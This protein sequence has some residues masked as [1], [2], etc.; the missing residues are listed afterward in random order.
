MPMNVPPD[1]DTIELPPALRPLAKLSMKPPLLMLPVKVPPDTD[2]VELSWALRPLAVLLAVHSKPPPLLMKPVRL[3]ADMDTTEVSAA[4][5]PLAE[6]TLQPPVLML[7]VRVAALSMTR[8][9]SKTL[10]A[11][12]LAVRNPPSDEKAVT[13]PPA[14]K[15]TTVLFKICTWSLMGDVTVLVTPLVKITSA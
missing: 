15:I 9:V 2:T 6:L 8:L 4:L 14:L 11:A 5:R 10:T 13:S 12:R 7:P 3:P 1:T